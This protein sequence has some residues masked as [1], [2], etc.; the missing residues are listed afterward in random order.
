VRIKEYVAQNQSEPGMWK[1]G[2][3]TYGRSG[4]VNRQKVDL[5]PDEV[6]IVGEALADTQA[7]ATTVC[8]TARVATIVSLRS[9]IDIPVD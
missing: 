9:E 3:H 1:L 4:R 5:L 7:L 2:F 8:D 6:F